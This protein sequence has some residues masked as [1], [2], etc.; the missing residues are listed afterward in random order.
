[1]PAIA[2]K[3]QPR[4]DSGEGRALAFSGEKVLALPVAAAL[5]L[6]LVSLQSRVQE[7]PALLASTL[8]AAAALLLWLGWH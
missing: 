7:N 4:Q 5:G 8:G 2:S 3:R 6:L 1:M